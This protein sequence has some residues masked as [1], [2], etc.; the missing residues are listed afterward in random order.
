MPNPPKTDRRQL[1]VVQRR[2][3]YLILQASFKDGKL[4]SGIIGA[5][6]REYS[7]GR[8]TVS[9]LWKE[10][11]DR[12]ANHLI[13]IPPEAVADAT[14]LSNIP[15]AVF[16][17]KGNRGAAKK[18]DRAEVIETIRA[19]PQHRRKSYRR[20]Q[21][22]TGIPLATLHCFVKQEKILYQTEVYISVG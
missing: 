14:N 3:I 18:W 10:S 9:N 15:E 5:T 8:K 22:A 4:L 12:L 20:L 21:A 13:T 16:S 19:V 7:V 2:E 11:R 1:T 17:T 6:A